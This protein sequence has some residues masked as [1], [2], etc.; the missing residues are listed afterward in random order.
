MPPCINH[1]PYFIA[2]RL[3]RHFFLIFLISSSSGV[4]EIRGPPG[5]IYDVF[6]VQWNA[7]GGPPGDPEG[8]NGTRCYIMYGSNYNWC[9][10]VD[11][12]NQKGN[13]LFLRK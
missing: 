12:E 10:G 13:N 4:G 6:P 11:A 8:V 3:G 2:E 5:D 9:S 1:E 7:V